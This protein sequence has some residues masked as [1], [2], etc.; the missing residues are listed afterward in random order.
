MNLEYELKWNNFNTFTEDGERII[1]MPP[2]KVLLQSSDEGV[3]GGYLDSAEQWHEF[4]GEGLSLQ[5]IIHI[6]L[7]NDG[8]D[9]PLTITRMGLD[10]AIM[11]GHVYN[12]YPYAKEIPVNGKITWDA[13]CFASKDPITNTEYAEYGTGWVA[14]TNYSGSD[15]VNKKYE[16]RSSE[17]C[18]YNDEMGNIEVTDITKE[19]SAVMV[20]KYTIEQDE[21]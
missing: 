14:Q 7:I 18:T 5:P 16:M 3:T 17:N 4:G 19:A 1:D 9:N 20:V 6:T 2:N 21:G 13:L 10:E 11:N 8:G 12:I 15:Y